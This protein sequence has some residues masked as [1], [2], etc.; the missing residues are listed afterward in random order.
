MYP[1]FKDGD[2]VI[3]FRMDKMYAPGDVLLLVFEGKVQ[4]R[5]VVATAG[6]VVDINEGGLTINGAL[7]QESGVYEETR[8]YTDGVSFPLTVGEGQVFVL[9]DARENATDSR[10]YGA[11]DVDDT[12]GKVI[13]ILRRRNI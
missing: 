6:D 8:R 11:V 10:V 13:N 2:Q 7:Q 3:F 9:A 5:R 4:I 12:M 1:A